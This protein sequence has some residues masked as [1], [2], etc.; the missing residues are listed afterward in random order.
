VARLPP[1]YVQVEVL[2]GGEQVGD[3]AARRLHDQPLEAPGANSS[4]AK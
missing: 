4:D 2:P 3:E 1:Q